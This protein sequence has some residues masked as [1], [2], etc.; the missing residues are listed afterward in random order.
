MSDDPHKQ[1]HYI[2]GST[3][4]GDAGEPVPV[5]WPPGLCGDADPEETGAALAALDAVRRCLVLVIEG[6]HRDGI[7]VRVAALAVMLELY[8]TPSQA[9][10]ALQVSASTVVRA[11][12]KL[13]AEVLRNDP[14][15]CVEVKCSPSH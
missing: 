10:K 6:G 14:R 4:F 7:P 8:A 11:L 9:A 5:T 3:G 1:S 12:E 2:I 13:R 15:F